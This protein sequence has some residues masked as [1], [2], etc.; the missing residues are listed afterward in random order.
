MSGVM[1]VELWL[2]VMVVVTQPHFDGVK[3]R[4]LPVAGYE[5]G[6]ALNR[7]IRGTSTGMYCTLPNSMRTCSIGKCPKFLLQG[8]REDYRPLVKT[9]THDD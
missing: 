5:A 8:F 6:Q 4:N 9:N 7:G 3:C 2:V 1:Q